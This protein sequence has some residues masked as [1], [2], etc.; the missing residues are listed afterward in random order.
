M[1][2][3]S[4]LLIDDSP[5]RSRFIADALRDQGLSVIAA[6]TPARGVAMAGRADLD[7]VVLGVL[8]PFATGAASVQAVRHALPDHALLVVSGRSDADAKVRCQELGASDVIGWPF[9]IAEF[10][11]RVRI[12][13]R[14]RAASGDAAPDGPAPAPTGA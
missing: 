11:A 9:A 6:P 7:L 8:T 1:R 10:L 5:A 4:I 3:G 12:Q 13:L 2:G 14:R